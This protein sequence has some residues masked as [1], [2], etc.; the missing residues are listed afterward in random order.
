[1]LKVVKI[2]SIKKIGLRKAYD[3][4]V[5][6]THNYILANGILTHNTRQAQESMKAMMEEYSKNCFFILSCN[7]VNKIIEP[8]RKGRCVALDFS[9]PDKETILKRLKEICAK[10]KLEIEDSHL[11]DLI[12]YNY[13]DM[14]AMILALQTCKTTGSVKAIDYAGF[15]EFMKAMKE[16]NVEYI[17]QKVYNGNFDIQ[18]F[19]RFLFERLFQK[20]EKMELEK[21]SKISL[22]LAEIEKSW[23]IGA[24]L[25]I[26]F[27][28]NIFEIMRLT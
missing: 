21:I 24:S 16:K 22:L 9:R 26:I 18:G 25:E 27:L 20:A 28:S 23:A 4:S 14:R 5:K 10:E 12:K 15:V 8:I 3:L 11:A 6:K 1:M 13:P 7:D 19:T 17:Y 2:K